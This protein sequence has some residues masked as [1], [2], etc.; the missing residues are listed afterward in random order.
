MEAARYIIFAA[1][2]L[3]TYMEEAVADGSGY[4]VTRILPSLLRRL[5]LHPFLITKDGYYENE[6]ANFDVGDPNMVRMNYLLFHLEELRHHPVEV[7]MQLHVSPR[8]KS[9]RLRPAGG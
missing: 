1:N 6:L 3:V 7:A 9:A 5:P 4:W 8:R 2:M